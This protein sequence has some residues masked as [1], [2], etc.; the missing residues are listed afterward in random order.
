[1]LAVYNW[2]VSGHF[3]AKTTQEKPHK[4][5]KIFELYQVFI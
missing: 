5:I 1:M 2:G 4:F 3:G